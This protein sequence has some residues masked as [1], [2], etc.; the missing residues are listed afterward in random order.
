[1]SVLIDEAG[2]PI[3]STKAQ[4]PTLPRAERRRMARDPMFRNKVIAGTEGVPTYYRLIAYGQLLVEEMSDI[5]KLMMGVPYARGRRP[6]G[7]REELSIKLTDRWNYVVDKLEKVQKEVT[8]LEQLEELSKN[9]QLEAEI[10]G[11]C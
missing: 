10:Y 2:A 3:E 9:P 1:M 7:A 5:Q 11:L 8:V 6:E 4:K